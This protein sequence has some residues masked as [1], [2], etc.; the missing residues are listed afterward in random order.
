[1]TAT[2]QIDEQ[3]A[4]LKDWRSPIMTKFRQL[5]LEVEPDLV[6][7]WKWKTGM[8][9]L[10]GQLVCGFAAFKNHVKFNFFDGVNLKDSKKLFN[11]GFEAKTARSIDLSEGQNVDE[12]ALKKLIAEAIQFSKKL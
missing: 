12:S 3:L 6:E 8:W 11:N 9:S 2:Q 1:M 5:V 7:E 10:N 4:N